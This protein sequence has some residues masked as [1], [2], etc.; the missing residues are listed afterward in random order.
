MAVQPVLWG[1][2]HLHWYIIFLET[3]A[4]F[5]TLKHFLSFLREYDGLFHTGFKRGLK[6]LKG[7]SVGKQSLVWCLGSCTVLITSSVL[8][9]CIG[10]GCVSRSNIWSFVASLRENDDH[11]VGKTLVSLKKKKQRFCEW[12][13]SYQGNPKVLRD[14]SK[15]LKQFL[16]PSHV[17]LSSSCSFR[18]SVHVFQKQMTFLHCETILYCSFHCIVFSSCSLQANGVYGFKARFQWIATLCVFLKQILHLQ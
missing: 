8:R 2:F 18:G 11:Y 17:F 7:V 1:D 14:N 15:A 5:I 12:M 13:Q 6:A 16:L 4:V 3:R 9:P 10:P